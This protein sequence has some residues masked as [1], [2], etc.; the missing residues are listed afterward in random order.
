MDHLQMSPNKP[1]IPP[2]RLSRFPWLLAYLKCNHLTHLVDLLPWNEGHGMRN[3]VEVQTVAASDARWL[4]G[5]QAASPA[6]RLLALSSCEFTEQ[7]SKFIGLLRSISDRRRCS[8][9]CS[10]L[11]Q[12]ARRVPSL[13]VKNCWGKGSET[14]RPPRLPRWQS[15][16]A[17]NPKKEEIHGD[18]RDRWGVEMKLSFSPRVLKRGARTSARLRCYLSEA[19]ETRGENAPLWLGKIRGSRR[20]F[21]RCC[22]WCFGGSRCNERGGFVASGSVHRIRETAE[23]RVWEKYGVYI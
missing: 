6:A 14:Q 4:F 8:L 11:T 7:V 12:H 13:S 15:K 18:G 1:V 5:R 19:H 21:R 17:A 16:P 22:W 10:R 23:N 2:H 3:G 20:L 9:S